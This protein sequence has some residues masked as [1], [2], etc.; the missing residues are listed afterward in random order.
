[1]AEESVKKYDKLLR[2]VATEDDV[3]KV[4]AMAEMMQ[5][6][7]SAFLRAIIRSLYQTAIEGKELESEE[8]LD[9]FKGAL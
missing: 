9:I 5:M 3:I 7:R 6:S 4:D 8:I 1:M 2:F